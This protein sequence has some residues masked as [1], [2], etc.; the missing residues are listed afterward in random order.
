MKVA[1]IRNS[2]DPEWQ[3]CKTISQNLISSYELIGKDNDLTFFN[4][5]LD[6]SIVGFT[7]LA[8]ELLNFSPEQIVW[9]E[10]QPTPSSFLRAL[11]AV[12]SN[13]PK[14]PNLKFHIYGDFVLNTTAWAS[15]GEILKEF[16]T[17][18]IAASEKQQNLLDGLIEGDKNVLKNCPFPVDSKSFSYS[19][20]LRLEKRKSLGIEDDELLIIYSGRLSFQKN[21]YHMLLC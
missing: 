11:E 8:Q 12:F 20:E 9:V 3:S 2:L 18:I 1:V 14:K 6:E 19:K 15:C 17:Q 7:K 10:Y 5:P 4:I 21:I 13:E 16:P